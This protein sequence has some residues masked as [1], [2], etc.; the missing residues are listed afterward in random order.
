MSV[1]V[2]TEHSTWRNEK[3]REYFERFTEVKNNGVDT[4][5]KTIHSEFK[6][7]EQQLW[8]CETLEEAKAIV[9]ID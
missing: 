3:A 8:L 7:K 9:G 4:K 6:R 1:S 2:S 5:I